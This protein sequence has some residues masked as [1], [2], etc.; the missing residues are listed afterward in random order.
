M[1]T[2]E[3]DLLKAAAREAR[4]IGKA[5]SMLSSSYKDQVGGQF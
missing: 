3:Q 5:A 1:R 4:S 2:I